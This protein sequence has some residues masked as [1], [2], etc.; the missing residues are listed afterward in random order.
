LMGEH[1]SFEVAE[2]LA[3][4]DTEGLLGVASFLCAWRFA[5]GGGEGFGERGDGR[6]DGRWNE[7]GGCWRWAV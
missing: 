4:G 7:G 1:V 5:T 6:R 2:F 3:A